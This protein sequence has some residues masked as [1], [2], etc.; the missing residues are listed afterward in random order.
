MPSYIV[1]DSATGRKL[2]LTGDS[3]PTEAELAD[4]FKAQTPVDAPTPAAAAPVDAVDHEERPAAVDPLFHAEMSSAP[5]AGEGAWAGFKK[6]L[7]E[8]ANGTVAK[9]LLDPMLALKVST[10]PLRMAQD[11]YRGARYGGA[12]VEDPEVAKIKAEDQAV[13]DERGLAGVYDRALPPVTAEDVASVDPK[14]QPLE[15][16]LGAVSNTARGL[17]RFFLTGPGILTLAGGAGFG[18]G[19]GAFAR[20]LAGSESTGAA[21]QAELAT[22]AQAEVLSHAA[23]RAVAGGFTADMASGLPDQLAESSTVLADPNASALD[24]FTAAIGPYVTASMVAATAKHAG[25]PAEAPT[26]AKVAGD[27]LNAAVNDPHIGALLEQA[28]RD[29]VD[30]HQPRVEQ[31]VALRTAAQANFQAGNMATFAA[32][33]AKAA[34][35]ATQPLETTKNESGQDVLVNPDTGTTEF[36]A[37]QPT[38]EAAPAAEVVPATPD[39]AETVPPSPPPA[40]TAPEPAKAAPAEVVAFPPAEPANQPAVANSPTSEFI[41][42]VLNPETNVRADVKERA[43]GKFAVTLLDVDSG[44]RFPVVQIFP[45]LKDAQQY[46]DAIA[47]GKNPPPLAANPSP[48]PTLPNDLARIVAADSAPEVFKQHTASHFGSS[49]ADDAPSVRDNSEHAQQMLAKAKAKAASEG[50]DWEAVKQKAREQLGLNEDFFKPGSTEANLAETLK[51]EAADR[52]KRQ[53]LA[54]EQLGL[55]TESKTDRQNAFLERTRQLRADREAKVQV[56]VDAAGDAGAVELTSKD[57]PTSKL[58]VTPEPSEPGKWRVTR[59]DEHGPVGHNVFDDRDAAVRAAA[60][61]SGT[62]KVKGPSYYR[63]GDFTV[64][65]VRPLPGEKPAAVEKAVVPESIKAPETAAQLVD[66]PVPAIPSS[67]IAT[68]PDLMQFKHMEDSATGI[69]TTD[70]LDGKW[71][72]RK[73]GVLLLWE[74]LSPQAHGL[75][76]GQKYI[77]ANGHHRFEFGQR[78][79]RKGYNAQ[80]LREADG[81]SA[82]D[83]RT[84]A[85]EVNIADGKGTIYDQAKFF[86]N[87]AATHGADES[88]A[89]GRRIGSRGR[90]AEDIGIKASDDLFTSFINE[91]I[92]PEATRAIANAAPGDANAQRIGI[93]FALEGKSPDFLTNVIKA[94]QAESG[95]RAQ[96]LDLFGADDS[97][98]KTMAEQAKRASEFQ[99]EIRDRISVLRAGRKVEIA[100]SEGIDVANPEAI[101]KRIEALKAEL[102]RWQNWPMQPDLVAKVRGAPEPSVLTAPESVAEQQARMDREQAARDAVAAKA[103]V[104]EAAAKPLTGTTGDLGQGDMFQQPEDLFTPPTP[105]ASTDINS[106]ALGKFGMGGAKPGEF[107]HDQ[108]STIST[109]NAAVDAER[110][111][112]GLPPAMKAAH[113]EWGGVWDQA[114]AT[115]DREPG[116]QDRLIES[117]KANPR[118]T[119]DLENALLLHRQIELQND[120]AKATREMAQAYEDSKTFPNRKAE[121]EEMRLLTADLSDKLLELYDVNKAV[122]SETGRGLAARKMLA[123]EDFTLAKMEAEKRAA[124]GGA[125]LSDAERENMVKLQQ[126]I[127]ETQAAFDAYRAKTEQERANRMTDEAIEDMK[128]EIAKRPPYD[129]RIIKIA[130]EIVTKLEK[131]AS[132]SDAAIREMLSRASSGLD[133][134]LLYHLGVKGAALI[135]RKGLDFTKF[136]LEMVETYGEKV[137]PYLQA[138]W[139]KAN[140]HLENEGAKYGDKAEPVKRLL[141]N[142]DESGRREN[143]IEGL[144]KAKAEDIPLK[145]SGDYIRKLALSF[146]RGGITEREALVDAVHKVVTEEVGMDITRRETMDAISGYG[147]FKPLDRDVAKATL[148]DLKGQMQQ[149]AKLE[150]IQAKKP[151]QKT[152]IERRPQSDEERRLIQQVN[153]AKRRHGVVVTDPARQLRSALDAVKTRLKNQIADLE[154]QI[155]SKERIIKSKTDAP[156]DA[157]SQLMEAR[158]DE[159][160]R[161]LDDLVPKP[162]RTDEQLLAASVRA[163]ERQIA[164]YEQRI[165]AG[166]TGI[167]KSK[168]TIT[169]PELDALKARRDAVRTQWQELRELS[170]EYQQQQAMQAM[171]RQRSSLEKSIADKEQALKDGPKPATDK[172]VNRPADPVLEPLIQK[173]DELNRRL[174]EARKKPEGQK[175]AEAIARQLESMK[176]AIAEREAKLASGDLSTNSPAKVNRPMASPE[177]EMARQQLD[178]VNRRLAEARK[179]PVKTAE[180]RQLASLKTRLTNLAADYA[181][182]LANKDFEPRQRKVVK[183]DPEAERLRADAER[184]KGEWRKG[185]LLDRLANRTAA[186]KTMDAAVRWHR[187]AIL[188]SPAVIAKLTSAAIYRTAFMPMEEAVK[189]AWAKALPAL[190]DRAPRQGGLMLSAEVKALSEGITTGMK[191]AWDMLR[192]GESNLD[193]AFGKGKD[194]AGIGESSVLPKTW[195][196]FFGHLHGALKA[197]VKRA[198]WARSM[199]QRMQ[200]NAAQGVDVSDPGVQMRLGVEAYKDAQRAIFLQDNRV[201]DVYKAALRRMEDKDKTTGKTPLRW[202]AAATAARLMLPIVKV[203]SNIVGEALETATGL[204][205]GGTKAAQAYR[206]GVESLKPQ[207][208]DDIMRQLSKGSLGGA[209]L[210]LGFYTAGNWGGFYVHGEK[211]KA[212]DLKPGTAKL[213]GVN[214][215]KNLLHYPLMDVVQMGATV[216]RVAGVKAKKS[217]GEPQGVPAGTAAALLGLVDESPFVREGIGL[218]NLRDPLQRDRWLGDKARSLAIPQAVQWTARQMDKDANGDVI[219][220][221]PHGLVQNLQTGIPYYRNSVPTKVEKRGK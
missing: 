58:L 27:M 68:R 104:A 40:T 151:L 136:S 158:R 119:T 107:E 18:A 118:A 201:V 48:I 67:E 123:Y 198:E 147:S 97:A 160:K 128:R 72:D 155:N 170:N 200:W 208:A 88:V 98:M 59:I 214:V 17:P 70:K 161:Q 153:E 76:E 140:V 69:N 13:R 115:I 112:R 134:E 73:A 25:T 71:D 187:A 193:L 188:S 36:P 219:R 213:D 26:V 111:K 179:G 143:I 41:H 86:R 28:G 173:R 82:A 202:K 47:F 121:V 94:S 45:K 218:D 182:R 196:D 185:L 120:Y 197:P 20:V 95:Q 125:P 11:V 93:K 165:A 12:P 7:R 33:K 89:T 177:L 194:P 22:A 105:K 91:Q 43:D 220:R 162:G 169:S 149:V 56:V 15:S 127:E 116:V 154:F 195:L 81:Y 139:D 209:L 49:A 176:K 192:T 2:K 138:A 180:E 174:A 175:A 204:L 216:A 145:L 113:R 166:E 101:P 21:L 66:E 211:R 8:T 6:A 90:A 171:E 62:E 199:E 32:L 80:V 99:K 172:P 146:V 30:Q 75:S 205:T 96:S 85:A 178:E 23:G 10:L 150:D 24:K 3:P 84:I 78:A 217:D 109:K 77:V 191:D 1:T 51:K 100:K 79:G 52:A 31:V 44:E 207:E 168:P 19:T 103:K 183:L 131:Q 148:R 184:A 130:E 221:D 38:P 126:R 55:K 14:L 16:A 106:G 37:P 133:P 167:K 108:R 186:E 157:E 190:A 42:S 9:T 215:D 110:V 65:R 141:R 92:S 50:W 181:E 87:T 57:S 74:P 63:A 129:S 53:A 34:E 137:K 35:V 54:D 135:A 144:K 5:T 46:A 164:D 64:T 210:L 132:K 203:P 29:M 114:M 117:L 212:D 159:L 122:G 152:G 189:A 61:E 83:A 142:Q 163:T 102:E 39:K 206:R 4:I 124:R 156:F 60:G